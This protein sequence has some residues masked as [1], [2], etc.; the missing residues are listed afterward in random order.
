M[1]SKKRRC[2]SIERARQKLAQVDAVEARRHVADADE[3]AEHAVAVGIAGEDRDPPPPALVQAAA[4]PVGAALGVEMRRD[5]P[6]VGLD[7]GRIV[8]RAEEAVERLPC[9]Q[10]AGRREL[11]PVE[12]D[13]R[14]AEID[15]GDAR[16]IGGQVGQHV[17]AARGDGHDV[18]VGRRAPAPR[19]RSRG[20]P[21]SACRPGRGT[22]ARTGAREGP[23]GTMLDGGEPLVSGGHGSRLADQPLKHSE[24]AQSATYSPRSIPV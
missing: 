8:G 4:L 22:A 11:Q 24:T 15:G 23:L 19:D 14:Q 12:R 3:A 17:A 7:V 5:Q 6:V 20:L 18:A 16:R 1:V 10:A 2:S 13:V 21:R 9:R